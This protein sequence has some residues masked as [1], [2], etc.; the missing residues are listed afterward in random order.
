M[1]YDSDKLPEGNNPERDTNLCPQGGEDRLSPNH[2]VKSGAFEGRVW[3]KPIRSPGELGCEAGEI[4]TLLAGPGG[5]QLL[6]GLPG[7]QLLDSLGI[8]GKGDS[9]AG[10]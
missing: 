1:H 7:Y 8:V 2:K 4:R 9:A 3:Q 6:A 10:F 5:G